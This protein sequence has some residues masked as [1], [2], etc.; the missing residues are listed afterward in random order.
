MNKKLG[1]IQEER[2]GWERISTGGGRRGGQKHIQAGS[3][4]VRRLESGYWAGLHCASTDIR[5]VL[6]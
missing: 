4:S 6:A 3:S 1:G 2:V 5:E